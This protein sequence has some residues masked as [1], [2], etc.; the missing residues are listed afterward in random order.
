[1]LLAFPGLEAIDTGQTRLFTQALRVSSPDVPDAE[2]NLRALF[3]NVIYWLLRANWCPD[4]GLGLQG[5]AEPEPAQVGQLLEYVVE[6]DRSGECVAAGVVVTNL[7]PAGVQ[8]V[9]AQSEQGG[10]S[11]DPVARQVTFSVGHIDLHAEPTLRV[12]VMPVTSGTITNLFGVRMNGRNLTSDPSL[13]LVTEV[14]EGPPLTP[15]LKLK[16]AG[17]PAYELSLSGVASVAYEV[18]TS[19][20]LK[21]WSPLT[22]VLG[23][24]WSMT[25]RPTS[26]GPSR[27]FY[28]AKLA[29]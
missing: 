16:L 23:P 10:W 15:N 25:A 5:I 14:Q 21:T 8:F 24:A 11:Y 4:V 29:Q 19:V 3:Q 13:L 20:D 26:G 18:Q 12:W 6:I 22:N 9:S 1:V 28:R 7:L 27:L 2:D 17:S